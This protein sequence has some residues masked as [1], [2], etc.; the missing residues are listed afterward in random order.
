MKRWI[1]ALSLLLLFVLLFPL[2]ACSAEPT[3]M[4]FGETEISVGMYRYWV[5]SY[6]AQFLSAYADMRDTD[7]FYD[8]ILTGNVTAEEFLN[9]VI[10]QNVMRN[11]IAAEWFRQYGLKMPD[12]AL[13]DIDAYIADLTKE[14]A[15][16]SRRALNELLQKYGVNADG[17]RE[18]LIME[19]QVRRLYKHLYKEGGPFMLSTAELDAYYAREYVRIR[20]IYVNTVY[21]YVLDENGNYVTDTNGMAVTRELT[22]EE[23]AEKA[24]KLADIAKALSDGT[25]FETVYETYSEDTLYE[26]GYYLTRDTA[27]IDE[28]V[29]AAFTLKEGE[30]LQVESP[31]GIHYILRLPLDEGA[32][33]VPENGDFFDGFASAAAEE[34]FLRR[35]DEAMEKV[36]VHEE[37][38]A[39][40]SIR[41]VS[42]NY[43]F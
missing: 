15:G 42:A 8:S 33:L 14:Y 3:A 35:L 34:D 5:S 12:S 22:E 26:N 23:Q 9:G 27:F 20:H 36:T 2:S 21:V 29:Q 39:P 7:A 31:F 38:L 19:E 18:I 16:G 40:Y 17:L 28:V 13:A 25:D 32:Y 30:Q 41:N 4:S 37:S 43:A 11:L 6:K 1:K 10:R 24:R